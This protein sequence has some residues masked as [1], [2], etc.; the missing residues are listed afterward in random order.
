LFFRFSLRGR[1][2]L[3]V[4]LLVAERHG[5]VPLHTRPALR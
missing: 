3:P 5:P 2:P 4:A 1:I